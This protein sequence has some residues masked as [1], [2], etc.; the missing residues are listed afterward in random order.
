MAGCGTGMEIRSPVS[1]PAGT[2]ALTQVN[3][4]GVARAANE[5][6]E[7]EGSMPDSARATAT[8]NPIAAR[9]PAPLGRVVVMGIG[10]SLLADDGVGIHVIHCLKDALPNEPIDWIDAGT[11]NFT[12]LEYLEHARA[13]VVVDAAELGEKP[14]TVRVFQGEEMDRMVASGRR[15]SVHEAGL[16][17][18]LAMARLKDWL[19]HHRAL[20]TV[21]PQRV[22]WGEQLSEPVAA[23]LP[24]LCEQARLLA[25]RWA[26]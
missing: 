3:A 21:Q 20:V 10:N 19:P 7:Q 22:D 24:G 4:T 6:N 23:A 12:L 2:G 1:G 17:D 11:L 13:L 15:N 8:S 5:R 18:V 25:Q 9:L 14:G 26:E 16:A